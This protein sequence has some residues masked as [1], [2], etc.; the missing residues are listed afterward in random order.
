MAEKS[1]TPEVRFKGFAD[2]WEQRKLGS[3]LAFL[4]NNTLSRAELSDSEGEVLNVHYGD[5]L[6]RYASVLDTSGESIPRIASNEVARN[7]SC[8]FLR[9]G[10]V[11]VADTAEDEAVGKCSELRGIGGWRVV[12]GLHTMPLRPF[13]EY[14]PGFLGHYINS[15]AFHEQLVPLMQ[16]IKVISI[17]RAAFAET[18]MVVTSIAE[19]RLIG[20]YFSRLDNL[21]TL[22]QRKH[23]KLVQLKKAM[24][25]KMFPKPGEL[26]PEVRFKGFA[27]PWEQRKLGDVFAEYSEKNRPDLPALTIIQGGGTIRRDESE[28]NLQYDPDSLSNYKAVGEGDFIVHLRSFEGGL[29][30]ATCCGLI[31]P[32]YHTF[33]GEGIDSTFYYLHFRSRKF[34]ETDLKPHVYGIRDGRS[35]DVEGMKTIL[36]P[37][38]RLEEQRLIGSYFS[39][40]DNL[41]TLHQRKLELLRNIKKAMLDKMFV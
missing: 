2:P 31:S 4:R 13:R 1:M 9:D 38:P 28:R 24:L 37:V 7:L 32:A 35:V 23:D 25:D 41:I 8:E 19:Q 36:I 27:D 40:L 22:H 16:G 5:V 12:S 11:V 6:V 34:I 29:E 26:V 21:I 17:S 10:D 30:R 3:E 15:S 33:H 14:A 20:S 39:R 18:V